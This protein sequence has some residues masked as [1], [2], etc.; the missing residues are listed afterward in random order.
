MNVG[1]KVRVVYSPYSSVKNGTIT[2]VGQIILDH[3]GPRRHL[4]IL[5]GLD[6]RHFLE[7]EI[8]PVESP[9]ATKKKEA[10]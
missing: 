1:D 9:Q 8:E 7:H 5:D 2:T 4:Y 10:K 6:C 3:F